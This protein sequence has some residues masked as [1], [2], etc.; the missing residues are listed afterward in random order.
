[1][2]PLIVGEVNP[3]GSQPQFALY[4]QPRGASGDRLRSILGLSDLAYLELFD[5]VNLCLGRWEYTKAYAHAMEILSGEREH[6]ITLGQQVS[7]AFGVP[8]LPLSI[9]REGRVLVLPHPSGRC[10]YWND[11][12][13]ADR[14]RETV[15]VFTGAF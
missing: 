10:L 5:R 12:D 14:A 1:V 15:R 11:P 6:I 2:R 9:H 3:Y 4:P 13:A 8:Y 7:R